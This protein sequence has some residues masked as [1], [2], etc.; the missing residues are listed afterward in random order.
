[1]GEKKKPKMEPDVVIGSEITID[2]NAEAP[3]APPSLPE[4]SGTLY[5]L[6]VRV[7]AEC[8]LNLRCG[9][10]MQHP[11]VALLPQ[12]TILCAF[13]AAP[14]V[15]GWMAVAAADDRIGWV[16]RQYIEPVKPE[17]A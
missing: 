6:T 10:G 2:P 7:T 1:M 11:I 3:D 16:D 15:E 9:P 8:G 14:E 17:E 12:D 13:L 4:I 5:P